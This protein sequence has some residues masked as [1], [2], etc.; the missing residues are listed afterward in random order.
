[1]KSNIA[2]I[3]IAILLSL[4]TAKN[5]QAA[6]LT[7][8]DLESPFYLIRAQKIDRVESLREFFKSF[9]SPLEDHAKIFV[10]VADKY[11]LDYRLLP[12]IACLESSC[13]KFYIPESNNPFGWGIYGNKV[14]KF[15]TMEEGIEVVGKG[16]SD[17]Y[18]EK[19][20]DTV[21]EIAPI[22]NPPNPIKWAGKVNYFYNKIN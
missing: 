12:S 5:A 16:L 4:V 8:S 3:A 7:S 11:G 2:H 22:Y 9:E 6:Q 19:G 18:I 17:N 15:A 1:M 14:T 10:Q 21:E 13:G 20:Y